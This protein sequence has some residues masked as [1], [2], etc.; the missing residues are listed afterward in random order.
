MKSFWV[1]FMLLAVVLFAAGGALA[2]FQA[3]AQAPAVVGAVTTSIPV[4]MA[5]VQV[6]GP[7]SLVDQTGK[8]VTEKSWPGKYKLVFFGFTHCPDTCPAT[9]QKL[10]AIM[11]NF[12]PKGAKIAPLF[13]TVDP[14]RDNA[15]AMAKYVANF[16]PV[17]SGL[18]GTEAQ[19]KAAEEA[20]RV[21]AAKRPGQNGQDYAEYMEDHSAYVYLMSPDDKL[22]Q[23]FS[24]DE[25]AEAMIAKIRESVK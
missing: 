23:T 15:A 10:A 6:G 17:I 4:P 21:Y 14:E 18:T 25:T 9:L 24:F 22:L 5:G 16:S 1:R 3:R 13:I 20:Y 19:I 12:D 7:F 2:L 11:Q 8:A